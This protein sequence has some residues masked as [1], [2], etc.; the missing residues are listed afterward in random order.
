MPRP[1]K[2][3]SKTRAK[4]VGIALVDGVTAAEKVTGIPKTTIQDWKNRPE[5]VQLRTT[6]REVVVEGLWVGIQIGVRE[7]TD[8]LTGDAPLNHKAAA[9][10]AL[11]NRFAL[12]NG[13]ATERTESHDWK[14]NDHETVERASA[15]LVEE[16]ARRT[17][18]SAAAAS[19]GTAGEAGAETAEG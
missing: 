18:E 10:E 8:G 17:D 1:R 11:A 19:V 3:D 7:L 5:Y 15:V 12:L 16:L 13:E 4:A 2:Y 14:F 9:F 6:A